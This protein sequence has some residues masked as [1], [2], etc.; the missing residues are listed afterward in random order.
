VNRDIVGALIISADGKI[1]LGQK[2]PASGAVYADGSWLIPGGGVEPGETTLE[3]L[4]REVL[5]EVGL[6][7]GAYPITPLE[8][9]SD[10]TSP[11]TL[12]TGE[13]VNVKMKF[14]N[15]RVDI[16]L[17]AAKIPVQPSAELPTLKWVKPDELKHHKLPPPSIEYFTKLGY[18]SRLD[19]APSQS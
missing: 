7:I 19:T 2:D 8:A 6:K 10:H 12:E 9:P 5:E 3:A 17:P 15:F 16:P 14:I 11:K 1:L 4:H 13:R 18:L